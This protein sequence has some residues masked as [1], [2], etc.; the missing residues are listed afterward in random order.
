MRKI[1][2]C[3]ILF[4]MSLCLFGCSTTNHSAHNTADAEASGVK[5]GPEYEDISVYFE[6]E[7]RFEQRLESGIPLPDNAIAQCFKNRNKCSNQMMKKMI[8]SGGKRLID[9]E[10]EFDIINLKNNKAELTINDEEPKLIMPVLMAI[11]FEMPELLPDAIQAGAN[12]NVFYE[13]GYRIKLPNPYSYT[14]HGPRNKDIQWEP[15]YE[16][17]P[18]L[19][20]MRFYY[21]SPL[22]LVIIKEYND[23]IQLLINAGANVNS[24]TNNG[25][26]ALIFATFYRNVKNARMLINAGADVNKTAVMN[27][28]MQGSEFGSAL[29]IATEGKDQEMIDLL[30]AHGAQVLDGKPEDSKPRLKPLLDV[31]HKE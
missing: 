24:R 27:Y 23:Y 19:D 26:T 18:Y 13:G 30:R 15:A 14:C 4:L 31:Y 5:N 8:Q 12:P 10:D 11:I 3:S 2:Q 1:L 17:R 6:Y 16:C 9:R 7:N 25:M 21:L 29:K 28:Y 22:M 20:S